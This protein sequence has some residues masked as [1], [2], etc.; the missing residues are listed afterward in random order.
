MV[1]E[2][3]V[4]L[5]VKLATKVKSFLIASKTNIHTLCESWQQESWQSLE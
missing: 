2:S 1:D 5:L 4:V 3:L